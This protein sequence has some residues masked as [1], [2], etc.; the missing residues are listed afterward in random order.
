MS[1]MKS[2][3]SLEALYALIFAICVL[4]A[5]FLLVGCERRDEAPV[6]AGPVVNGD[7]VTF[8]LG[9]PAVQRLAVEKV[10]A[11]MEHS[12]ALPGRL[13]WDE[14]H[15]VRVFTPFAGRVTHILAKV[16]DTVKPGQPLVE[17]S[18]PDYAQAQ[19]DARKARAD[20]ALAQ[21]TVERQRELGRAGIASAKDLEQAETDFTR[22]RAEADRAVGRLNAYGH[23]ADSG[24]DFV[25]KS[26]MGGTIVE[27]NLNPGQ[28]LRPDQP[29]NPLFVITD[30]T[31]LWASLDANEADLR[32][33]KPGMALEISSTQLPDSV[34]TGVLRQVA[35]FVDPVSRTVK[36]RGDVPNAQRV[37][38]AEMFVTAR[39]KVAAPPEPTVDSR[40]VY[41][42]GAQRYAFVRSGDT[43]YTR[44]RVRVGPEVEGRMPVREGLRQGEDVVVAGNLYLDQ[45]VGTE[46]PAQPA[47]A[48]NPHTALQP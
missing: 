14:D 27:R 30:P 46:R 36:L 5:L 7:T 23:G 25:L 41:L 20:L 10:E 42:I 31:R 35:D 39:V 26:P 40:A 33:V 3:D 4:L 37:L 9:S 1:R 17:M 28:E 11:P 44:R 29:G 34:F 16:G 8:A 24:P 48:E 2:Q 38:K 13:A 15:T 32:Y 19:A 6:E 45:I 22:A 18:S 12:L 47:K 21:K 43:S